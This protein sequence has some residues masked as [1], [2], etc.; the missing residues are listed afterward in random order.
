M[1]IS[2]MINFI[3]KDVPLFICLGFDDNW[4]SGLEGSGTTGGMKWLLDL[5]KDKKNFDGSPVRFTFF[6]TGKHAIEKTEEHPMYI[7][8]IWKRAFEEGHDIA[9]HTYTHPHG[10]K[11]SYE[12]WEEEIQKC[13]KVLTDVVGIKKEE[14]IGYRTPY[15]E[16]NAAV[17]KV[18]KDKGLLYDSSI[19]EGWQDHFD[20]TNYLWPYTLD[21][22]SPG[23]E[24]LN[25]LGIR[26]AP[27]KIEG[28]LELPIY[29][30]IV[31]P[32][33]VC[34]KYGIEKGLRTKIKKLDKNFDEK[35]G[36]VTGLD[37][38]MFVLC[39]MNKDEFVAT[40]K[41]TLDLKLN[42]NKCP[43]IFGCHSDIYT[44][45]YDKYVNIPNANFIER[46]NAL[47]EFINYALS[48]PNVKISSYKQF[49]H[50]YYSVNK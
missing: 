33:D 13:M 6:V 5:V 17:F 20:G 23:G 29:P 21:E 45:I 38:N 4:T 18:V 48:F 25:K 14:I 19:E 46:Q 7:K 30:V 43:F 3:K 26:E 42:G 22:G 32:D 40:L 16:Y 8:T 41:Y 34:Y 36:K 24:Y 39:K 31:P 50:W 10:S 12:Q 15:L 49:Y 28:I 37:Y 9:L 27:A 47:E 35:F 11:L 44:D 2:P 1:K